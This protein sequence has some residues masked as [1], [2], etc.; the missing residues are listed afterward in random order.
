MNAVLEQDPGFKPT[1]IRRKAV[2]CRATRG[3]ESARA[4]SASR[5][6]AFRHLVSAPSPA[7]VSLDNTSL[8]GERGKFESHGPGKG[9]GDVVCGKHVL[10]LMVQETQTE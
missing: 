5:F 6:R 10:E 1:A 4:I 3:G 2:C 8:R 9:I 7:K